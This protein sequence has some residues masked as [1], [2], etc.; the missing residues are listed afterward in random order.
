M[1]TLL[2]IAYTG[3]LIYLPN[4]TDE[5]FTAMET[6]RFCENAELQL[7]IQQIFKKDEL[8]KEEDLKSESD[9][10]KTQIVSD[11][12]HQMDGKPGNPM[13]RGL[14]PDSSSCPISYISSYKRRRRDD[15]KD[16]ERRR[17][18]YE[19]IKESNKNGIPTFFHGF[20]ETTGKVIFN[21]HKLPEVSVF[22]F[23]LPDEEVKHYMAKLEAENTKIK[24]KD[25]PSEN[26]S[27][28]I[29][30]PSNCQ[31]PA[32]ASKSEKAEEVK[33]NC[34]ND[35]PNLPLLVSDPEIE[36]GLPG[37]NN[38]NNIKVEVT[39]AMLK[40]EVPPPFTTTVEAIHGL[41]DLISD[42]QMQCC[43]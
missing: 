43:V 29:P 41:C 36:P 34:T 42:I 25:K 9:S 12:R 39:T 16:L 15:P 8:E 22:L 21:M 11:E 4:E 14:S 20:N 18:K 38:N 5:V 24:T 19:S 27:P 31:D 10:T 32:P 37:H 33:V 2:H 7:T 26:G 30:N 6:L 13:K 1:E 23:E 3:K 17:L 28:R 40:N 35:P